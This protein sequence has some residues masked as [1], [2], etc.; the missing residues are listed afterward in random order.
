LILKSE[1]FVLGLFATVGGMVLIS[2]A[3]LITLYLGL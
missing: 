2:A 1:Y 3:S